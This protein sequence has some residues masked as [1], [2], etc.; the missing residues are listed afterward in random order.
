MKPISIIASATLTALLFSA[1]SDPE[2]NV[3]GT[4]SDGAGKTL[5]LEKADHAGIWIPID[6]V[7][8]KNSGS[9]S[10][11]H[12][13]P[14]Y[15][16]IFRLALDGN[17]VYFPVDSVETITLNSS[18]AAFSTDFTLS[19]SDQ[20][21]ALESFEK[22]L[23]AA[24]AGLANPD[25]AR[26]F[27]RHLFTSYLQNARG[28]VVSYYILTK[29]VGDTPLFSATEDA[30]YFAAVA[31]AMKEY[32]PDDPRLEMLT[33]T[34]TAGRRS[35]KLES[36]QQSVLEVPEI[37]YIDINLP[38][39]DGKETKLSSLVGKGKPVALLFSDLSNPDTPALNAQLRT[40]TGLD[41]YNVGL[42]EDQLQWRNAA[43]NLPWTCVFANDSEAAKLVN[44]YN[45]S[46]L[47]AIF[48][49]DAAGNMKARCSSIAEVKKYL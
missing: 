22:E 38:A 20:A 23:I 26:N 16:E 46:S 25:S 44:S 42:D 28:S 45:L 21:K 17:Y 49:F 36:S 14:A 8:I 5:I 18:L 40:L 1:C 47:P 6:S 3:K 13:A 30:P 7:K 34:A 15:P 41:I 35:K 37:S 29:T 11:K 2:F 24:S 12:I 32:R 43:A 4:I 19:G 27:K 39:V 9:F 10:I 48:I 33:R 31:T